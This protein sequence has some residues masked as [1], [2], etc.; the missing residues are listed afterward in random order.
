MEAARARVRQ[1]EKQARQL[2][3]QLQSKAAVETAPRPAPRHEVDSADLMAQATEAARL[4]AQISRT[5]DEYQKRPRRDFVGANAKNYAYARYVEDWVAKVEKIGNLNY[6]EAARQQRIYGSLSLTVSL[7][8]DGTVEK[9]EIEKTSGSK[10]LDQAAIN[11]VNL[12]APYAPFPR[13]MREAI[14]KAGGAPAAFANQGGRDIAFDITRTWRF[15]R[16]DQLESV[17]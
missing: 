17:E 3:T 15:T 4:Q 10:I 5:W 8:A 11:I 6:P 12:G 2:M 16:S 9:V 14:W 1:L 13:E 7:Y